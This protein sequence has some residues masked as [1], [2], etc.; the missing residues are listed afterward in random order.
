MVTFVVYIFYWCYSWFHTIFLWF[1]FLFLTKL[2]FAILYH[3]QMCFIPFGTRQVISEYSVTLLKDFF[4][5][6]KNTYFVLVLFHSNLMH[7][8]LSEKS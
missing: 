3:L 2:L 1:S 8:I 4:F 7:C 6:F 5:L